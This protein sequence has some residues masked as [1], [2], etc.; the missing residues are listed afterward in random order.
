MPRA[1]R[2]AGTMGCPLKVMMKKL[3]VPH[4]RQKPVKTA[5]D[6]R[7]RC[8]AR[9]TMAQPRPKMSRLSTT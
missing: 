7:V 2:S 6:A 3:A 1:N 5:S 4:S 9:N 8:P